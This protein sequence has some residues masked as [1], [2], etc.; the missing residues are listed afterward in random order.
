MAR[1]TNQLLTLGKVEHDG[2]GVQTEAV[3]LDAVARRVVA[4]AA[5]RALDHHIELV[6]DSKGAC[7]ALATDMLAREILKN[8]VDNVIAHAGLGATATVSVHQTADWAEIRVADD[9]A[10]IDAADR[11]RLFERFHRGRGAVEGGSGL[12]LSIVAEIARTFGGSVELPP[13]SSGRGFCVVVRLKVAPMPGLRG[14]SPAEAV[15]P[16]IA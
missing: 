9:G 2:G 4:D 7:L 3:D 5:P 13:P 15:G 14:E 8:L 6:L 1:L 11:S 10:G 16:P 12:G